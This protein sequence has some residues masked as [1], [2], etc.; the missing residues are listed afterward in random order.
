[1]PAR[2]SRCVKTIVQ[3]ASVM[4]APIGRAGCLRAL[5]QEGVGVHIALGLPPPPVLP[6]QGCGRL[7]AYGMKE[8]MFPKW[9]DFKTFMGLIR[10]PRMVGAPARATEKSPI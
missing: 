9:S 5:L 6:P 10:F 1:M 2:F 7:S 3:A 4:P 8:T